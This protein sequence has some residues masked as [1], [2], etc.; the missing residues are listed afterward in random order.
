MTNDQMNAMT[1]GISFL[2]INKRLYGNFSGRT[3]IVPTGE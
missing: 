3:R 1:P 2:K